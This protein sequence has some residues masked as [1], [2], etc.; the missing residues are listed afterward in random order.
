ME[1]YM[2]KIETFFDNKMSEF[3][4]SP[5]KTSIKILVILWLFKVG[6]NWIFKDKKDED[7]E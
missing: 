1:K 6:Y 4:K 5:I 7:D 2:S 3:E